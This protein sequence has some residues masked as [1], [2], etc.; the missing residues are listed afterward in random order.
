MK[1]SIIIPVMNEEKNVS[2]MY[3]EI[4]K[5]F[6][7]KYEIIFINDGSNDN[8]KEE[9]DKLYKKDNKHVKVI[10]FSR[11]FGKD[12]AIYAGLKNSSGEYNCIIDG[13]MQQSPKY[14]TK[15]V[16]FLDKN[17]TYSEVAMV[18]RKRNNEFFFKS[19]LIKL[20]YK[21]INVI[22]DTKFHKDAGDFRMFR[23][24]VKE[25]ILSFKEKNRFTKGIFNY[26]GFNIYYMKYDID[27]RYS[28]KTKFNIRR[29]FKYAI[30]GIINYSSKPLR[31]S[32]FIG[33]LLV[34]I[35]IICLI[36]NIEM[37]SNIFI[38]IYG[39]LFIVLNII[40]LYIYN[41]F[42]EVKNRPMYII[43]SMLGI[44]NEKE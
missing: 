34:I 28:G 2:K 21:T 12:A 20:F 30:N 35:G 23:N 22:S 5:L 6:S 42:I 3:N 14:L 8:T 32:Y 9:L 44:K 24:N 36:L 25:A 43:E 27:K 33:L 18:A 11:N 7:F 1:L 15:M 16:N 17:P 13:D 26:I 19:L 39:L 40:G 29:S 38:I 41:I 31:V 4:I 37:N 10:N